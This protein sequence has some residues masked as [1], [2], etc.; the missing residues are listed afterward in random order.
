MFN[1]IVA[2][3]IGFNNA[4]FTNV[5]FQVR[6]Q[7]GIVDGVDVGMLETIVDH[8]WIPAIYRHVDTLPW[9]MMFV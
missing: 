8:R 9:S 7:Q 2:S 6:A 1:T 4:I 3:M 5:K